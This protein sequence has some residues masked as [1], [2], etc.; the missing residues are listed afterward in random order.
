MKSPLFLRRVVGHSM[1][2]TLSEGQI[3]AVSGLMKPRTG[4]LVIAK[5]DGLEVVKR[6]TAHKT[7]K[8]TLASDAP[9]HGV[10]AL[11]SESDISGR[12]IDTI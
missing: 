12:V 4:D 5:V 8:F 6:V 9:G 1:S 10:Y 11:V 3:V 7:D 2:P